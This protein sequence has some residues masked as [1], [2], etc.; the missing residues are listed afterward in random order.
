[1]KEARQA[2]RE[3]YS[4][5]LVIEDLVQDLVGRGLEAR[6]SR[7]L[8]YKNMVPI[9]DDWVPDRWRCTDVM[10]A[11]P[12]R[13]DARS[14]EGPHHIILM[15]RFEF[16]DAPDMGQRIHRHSDLLRREIAR[17]EAFGYP[18]NL[19]LLIPVVIY[20]GNEEW[21]APKDEFNRL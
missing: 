9:P 11:I 13:A 8:D 19:P 3:I 20:T 18:D 7:G 5:P 2:I 6:W 4:N 21:T 16:K 17:R 1:M 14:K 10:W 12:L 15:V